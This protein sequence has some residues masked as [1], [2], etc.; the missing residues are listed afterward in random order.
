MDALPVTAFLN[1]FKLVHI[2]DCGE[3]IRKK[4]LLIRNPE[5]ACPRMGVGPRNK[6]IIKKAK[7]QTCVCAFR[8]RVAATSSFHET[9]CS[10]YK[11]CKLQ[12]MLELNN[13]KGN[14]CRKNTLLLHLLLPDV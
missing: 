6:I 9:Q 5:R 10:Y 1:V 13:H 2:D 14:F 11:P 8:Q 7:H 3:N 12:P 4:D